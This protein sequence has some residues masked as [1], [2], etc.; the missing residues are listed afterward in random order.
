MSSTTTITF[1]EC[2]E[3]HRGM[4]QIGTIAPHGFSL[5]HLQSF[6]SWFE[7]Q[8]VTCELISLHSTLEEE[9]Y[10]VEP[11]Y[12]LILR[13]AATILLKSIGKTADDLKNEQ[14]ALEKD[15][16]AF[17]YGR[18]VQKKARWNLCFADQNRPANYAEG[19]GTI[20]SFENVPYLS[21]VRKQL[22]SIFPTPIEHL[23]AEGNYY[24]DIEKTYIG[25][26]GDTERRIVIGLRLGA[27]F[28]LQYQWFQRSKPVGE[29]TK[30]EFH[31]GDMY[32]MSDK[33]VGFDWK[34]SSIMTLRHGAGLEKF[35]VRP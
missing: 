31:H 24:Y 17:M 20:V 6:R 32:M 23:Y 15:K 34:R 2:V 33:A 11:A 8:G 1:S 10:P 9:G 14:D 27:T 16:H 29:A 35:L 26:H 28:P 13:S 22:L 3:N 4:E 12:V 5:E 25:Y 7:K 21:H 19:K 30:L 18:V